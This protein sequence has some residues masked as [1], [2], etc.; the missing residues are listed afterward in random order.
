MIEQKFYGIIVRRDNPKTGEY[1]VK[2]MRDQ[3]RLLSAIATDMLKGNKKA[4]TLA[5]NIQK[6]RIRITNF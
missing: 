6:C 4:R 1:H 3:K 5:N 2:S